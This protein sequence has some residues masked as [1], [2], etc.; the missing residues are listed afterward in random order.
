MQSYPT[1]HQF[2]IDCAWYSKMD[3][4]ADVKTVMGAEPAKSNGPGVVCRFIISGDGI[5]DSEF[6]T[7]VFVFPFLRGEVGE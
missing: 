2:M 7:S 1:A 4:A 6:G 5:F 3:M